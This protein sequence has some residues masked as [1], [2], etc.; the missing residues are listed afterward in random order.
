MYF[1][2]R[3]PRVEQLSNMVVK[4]CKCRWVQ[5]KRWAGAKRRRM[6]TRPKLQTASFR[7]KI[8]TK[9]QTDPLFINLCCFIT[10]SRRLR[11]YFFMLPDSNIRILFQFF[12]GTK[13]S[14]IIF[15][16]LW[17][18]LSGRGHCKYDTAVLNLYLDKMRCCVIWPYLTAA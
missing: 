8:K 2:G 5:R 1:I 11:C 18:F 9:G 14:Q 3:T 12:A 13:M 16:V 15:F 6:I 10:F 17:N 4:S 7:G